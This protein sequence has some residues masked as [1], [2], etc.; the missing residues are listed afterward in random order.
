MPVSVRYQFSQRLSVS[1]QKAFDW[2]T[3]FSPEDNSLM[4][5][6]NAQREIISVA[7]GSLLLKD[8]FQTPAGTVE[9]QKLV[10]LYP[11]QLRWISTHLSGPN[12][13]SQFLY[14]ITPQG[15]DAAV[16]EFTAL[17]IEH[18]DKADAEALAERL[19]REDAAAWIRLAKA[20]AEDLKK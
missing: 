8:T 6:T 18:D 4:G 17:H 7:D 13:Y 16:L 20:M 12:R 14:A 5:D 19:C 3:D 9:K 10:A 1:A 11:E 15:K 2:C